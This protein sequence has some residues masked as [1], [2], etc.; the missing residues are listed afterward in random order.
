MLV[1]HL[2][3]H[4]GNQSHQNPQNPNDL[5]SI[6]WDPTAHLPL[7]SLNAFPCDLLAPLLS[8]Y[9]ATLTAAF[10]PQSGNCPTYQQAAYFGTLALQFDSA[11]HTSVTML[12]HFNSCSF[13]WCFVW[14]T[15]NKIHPGLP[16]PTSSFS[17]LSMWFLDAFQYIQQFSFL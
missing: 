10:Q 2:Q 8:L 13:C 5:H 14:N 1:S 9:W 11:T 3:I 17:F 7:Q 4:L 16:K 6:Y 12:E 15:V